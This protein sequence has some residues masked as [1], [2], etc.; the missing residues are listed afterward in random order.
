[1]RPMWRHAHTTIWMEWKRSYLV[2]A[3][4]KYSWNECEYDSLICCSH[5]V[6][7]V[8]VWPVLIRPCGMTTTAVAAANIGY[9]N[10]QSKDIW[11]LV[12]SGKCSKTLW[13][14]FLLPLCLSDNYIKT[15]DWEHE[16]NW[17]W[18]TVNC[19]GLHDITFNTTSVSWVWFK[20]LGK[21]HRSLPITKND[22]KKTLETR[23][24]AFE[25]SSST[26]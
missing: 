11:S 24:R 9:T 22:G 19:C 25:H 20:K 4:V 5:V 23:H 7:V 18:S 2:R 14:C 10:R 21:S 26:R 17:R 16:E 12:C 3:I 13:K 8:F 1:M 15:K 6:C